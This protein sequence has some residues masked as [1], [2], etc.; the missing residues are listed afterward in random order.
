MG[1]GPLLNG[2]QV[3]F[4]TNNAGK[5]DDTRVTVSVRTSSGVMADFIDDPLVISLKTAKTVIIVFL[6]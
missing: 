3:I 4:D 2:A 1:T 6:Q 5:N